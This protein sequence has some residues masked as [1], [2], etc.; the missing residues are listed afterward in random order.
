[1]TL[2]IKLTEYYN[3]TVEGNAA[4]GFI[5]L[6]V[7]ADA[8]VN[9]LGFKA[10]PMGSNQTQFT[11]FPDDSSKMKSGAENAGIGLDGPYSAII[12]QGGSDEPGDCANVHEKLAQAGVDVKESSGIADIKE[13]YGIILYIDQEDTE[14][15]MKA[16]KM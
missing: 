2:D 7:F 16:L 8:G 1:M 12:V 6:S 5:L 13:S 11:L 3:I 9:L 15:A 4:E 14:K 10:V